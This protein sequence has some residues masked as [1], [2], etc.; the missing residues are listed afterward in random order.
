MILHKFASRDKTLLPQLARAWAACFL[1][2]A[3]GEVL[4]PME[5]PTD[6]FPTATQIVGHS[7]LPDGWIVGPI[8]AGFLG[9][10]APDDDT[11]R[12]NLETQ[13][14]LLDQI[15]VRE[16][17]LD[18]MAAELMNAYDQLVAMY[19][20]SEAA[21]SSL[22]MDDV[23]ESLIDEALRLTKSQHSFVAMERDGEFHCVTC[24]HPHPRRDVLLPSLLQAIR[25]RKQPL[26]C[27]APSE[28]DAMPPSM[29]K[30]VERCLVVPAAIDG[31]VVAILGLLDKSTDF[32]AGDQKL[33]VAL[34]DE[35]GSIVERD[36]LQ[37][38]LV[39]RE[40]LRRELEIA[41]EIQT[42]L[43][44]SELPSV[45]GLD[46]AARSRPATEVGGDF[47]DFI[48]HPQGALA[49]VVGDVTGKGVPAALFVTVAHNILHRVIPRVSG[50]QAVLEQLNAGLYD[51]LTEA[52]MFITLLV[53]YYHPDR[54]QLVV[55]N[56]G[57][58]P[59][60]HYSADAGRCRLLEA[61]GPPAGVLP[62]VL[63]ADSV[64]QM[65]QGD[66]LVVMSDGFNEM[67][68]PTGEMFGVE[69]LMRLLEQHTERSA[70]E[71]QDVLFEAVTAFAQGNPQA[72]DMTICILKAT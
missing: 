11:A 66:I 9:I 50:P 64:I 35:V 10:Y 7:P 16:Q 26:L 58:S 36:R 44:P 34:A 24:E 39:E 65:Q 51:E 2:D 3:S 57:H 47:Y 17:E 21:R 28:L 14:I 19:H 6:E 63:S 31:E 8:H 41:A 42:R 69:R 56:A 38:Q 68:N 72:D 32:T 22:K 13:A 15:L 33:I 18:S 4:W 61:D 43:L 12:S 37:T 5:R 49:V 52:S 25:E 27:N 60:L 40:R 30:D 46:V 1:A 59:V 29:P 20:I 53:A 54:R 45:P 71:I 23:L 67:E 70:A 62:D 48:P 55:A